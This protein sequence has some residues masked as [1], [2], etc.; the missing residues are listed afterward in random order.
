MMQGGA[1]GGARGIP[2]AVQVLLLNPKKEVL[3]Q[4]R[5]GTGFFDGYWSLPGGHVEPDESLGAA[6]C[7]ELAEE[8]GITVHA[9]D[10]RPIG[11]IHRRSDT[12]RIEFLFTLSRWQGTPTLCEPHR[13]RAIQ[14]LPQEAPPTP[15]VPYLAAIW[16]RLGK[17]WLFEWGW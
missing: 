3:F 12:N 11:V 7:R 10:L 2:T 1:P 6:A 15:L 13:A 14:W 4:L 8:L 5:R 17:Q 16:P 9:G